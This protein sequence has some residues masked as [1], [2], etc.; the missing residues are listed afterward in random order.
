MSYFLKLNLV[1]ITTTRER[2]C[3]ED[4]QPEHPLRP[5]RV[6]G[7]THDRVR[8]LQLP[9]GVQIRTDRLARTGGSAAGLAREPG[10]GDSRPRAA[11]ALRNCI[12][13]PRDE[14]GATVIVINVVGLVAKVRLNLKLK[15]MK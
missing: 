15:C 12:E 7:G 2:R 3:H 13:R 8:P 11:D 6:R 4:E 9:D 5:A 14:D 10:D 1:S